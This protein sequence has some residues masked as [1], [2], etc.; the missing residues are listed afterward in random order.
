MSMGRFI[1][2]LHWDLGFVP[3]MT[4]CTRCSTMWAVFQIIAPF[5]SPILHGTL[6]IEN[7]TPIEMP[8]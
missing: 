4:G 7:Y 3:N 1:S 6:Y 8:Y 5:G 2:E